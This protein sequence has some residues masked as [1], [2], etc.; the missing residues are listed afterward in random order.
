[1]FLSKIRGVRAAVRKDKKSF[2]AFL[3]TC[4]VTLAVAGSA[5]AF[6]EPVEGDLF[7]EVYD[8]AMNQIFS[9]AAGVVIAGIM[10][11]GAFIIKYGV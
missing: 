11:V 6:T 8:L 9:S 3:F 4:L 5:W 7:Y 1:M 2:T 10:V